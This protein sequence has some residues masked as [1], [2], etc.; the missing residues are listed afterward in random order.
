MPAQSRTA[1]V[2]VLA[3]VGFL[4]ASL[5][6]GG[7]G[8]LLQGPTARVTARYAA[9]ELPSWAPDGSVFGIVWPVLYVLIALAAWQL[10]RS[11]SDRGRLRTALTLWAAQLVLNAVWP[12][13]FFGIP[14]PGAAIVVIVVLDVTVALTI[15]A[16]WR[17][18]RVAALLLAP[19]LAWI[20]FATALNVAVWMMNPGFGG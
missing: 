17:H 18:D 7:I 6:A 20:L 11:T 14:A 13:V 4:A 19:Y 3:L 2:H 1:R 16:F 5:A 12:G 8:A 10:W 15:R 9:F